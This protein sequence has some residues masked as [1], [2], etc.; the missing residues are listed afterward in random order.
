MERPCTVLRVRVTIDA[1]SDSLVTMVIFAAG[2]DGVAR[3]RASATPPAATRFEPVLVNPLS[4]NPRS[5]ARTADPPRR[6][7]ARASARQML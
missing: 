6:A 4:A 1:Y 2:G 5:F 3:H 7:T